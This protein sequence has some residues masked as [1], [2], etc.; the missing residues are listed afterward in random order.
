MMNVWKQ[1]THE[2]DDVNAHQ[3]NPSC[4]FFLG[5]I[6]VV[7]RGGDEKQRRAGRGQDTRMVD[8]S[9]FSYDVVNYLPMSWHTSLKLVG[10]V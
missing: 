5:G 3:K 4:T 6:S 9:P 1:K 10:D 7:G 8:G 2:Y